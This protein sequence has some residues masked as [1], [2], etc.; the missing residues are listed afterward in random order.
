MAVR[1]SPRGDVR[2]HDLKTFVQ[3]NA[4]RYTLAGQEVEAVAEHDIMAETRLSPAEIATVLYR[5]PDVRIWVDE[6]PEKGRSRF[7]GAERF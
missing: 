3:Q 7:Y 4:E 1:P 5:D 6:H 2:D